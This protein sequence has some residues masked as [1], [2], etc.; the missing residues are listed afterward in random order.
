M[1]AS[2][3]LGATRR[4]TPPSGPV[5]C[6]LPEAGAAAGER[7]AAKPTSRAVRITFPKTSRSILGS[8]LESEPTSDSFHDPGPTPSGD[9]SASTPRKRLGTRRE[10][11]CLGV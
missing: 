6:H 3:G 10:V 9:T 7:A 4:A 5:F 11:V 8:D 2:D 1:E